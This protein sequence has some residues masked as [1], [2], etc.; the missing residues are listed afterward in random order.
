MSGQPN[1]QESLMYN[2]YKQ[3][4]RFQTTYSLDYDW[5]RSQQSPLP[6]QQQ[7]F[8]NNNNSSNT[9]H[10][11]ALLNRLIASRGASPEQRLQRYYKTVDE[12]SH[13]LIS[14]S[15]TT[16]AANNVKVNGSNYVSPSAIHAR[17][18]YPYINTLI[19]RATSPNKSAYST[20]FNNPSP[21]IISN[22][23]SPIRAAAVG[24]GAADQYN[25][26]DDNGISRSKSPINYQDAGSSS[27]YMKGPDYPLID[28]LSPQ[29][30]PVDIY[31]IVENESNTNNV[32]AD[33]LIR[34]SQPTYPIPLPPKT[35][36]QQELPIKYTSQ[37]IFQKE[38]QQ[39]QQQYSPN[40]LGT[41][42]MIST[43]GQQ[44]QQQ[45]QQQY[46]GT[47]TS[48]IPFHNYGWNHKTDPGAEGYLTTF[49]VRVHKDSQVHI[50]IKIIFSGE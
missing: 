26:N 21:T 32:A 37:S 47:N 31:S 16:A 13:S 49:N 22:N 38:G 9:N 12:N 28:I 27:P 39:Q 25:N 8:L 3:F 29:K 17:R 4:Q 34:N 1:Q 5:K 7:Q 35:S 14:S 23:K 44:Q 40:S 11:S 43:K 46:Q 42:G 20:G 15:S 18:E 50:E 36:L 30:K 2:Q 10:T 19:D 48:E 24:W 41:K 6:F 33:H 45:Q